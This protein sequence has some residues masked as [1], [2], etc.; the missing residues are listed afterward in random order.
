MAAGGLVT[1]ASAAISALVRA[2][3]SERNAIGAL[4]PLMRSALEG[5]ERRG[6]ARA[7]TGPIIRGDWKVVGEHLEALPSDLRNLYVS[8]AQQSLRLASAS[9]SSESTRRLQRVLEAWK[10]SLKRRE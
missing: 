8:L 6:P 3:V 5:I 1:L 9:L 2:G 7:L 10:R 4:L